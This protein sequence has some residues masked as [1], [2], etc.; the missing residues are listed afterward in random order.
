MPISYW[1]HLVAQF[2]GTAGVCHRKEPNAPTR[3]GIGVPMGRI[4]WDTKEPGHCEVEQ[5]A[6]WRGE[7]RR[8]VW[9]YHPDGGCRHGLERTSGGAGPST[10]SDGGRI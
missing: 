7:Q 2:V 10:T 5:V 6:S 4:P 1:S 8:R 9:A 3:C